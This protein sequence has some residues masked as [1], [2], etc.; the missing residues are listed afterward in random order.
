MNYHRKRRIL[1]LLYWG[2]TV[3]VLGIVW[4]AG[5][6]DTSLQPIVSKLVVGF[7]LLSILVFGIGTSLTK[8][9][10][11]DE[12]DK[13]GYR[14]RSRVKGTQGHRDALGDER[15][16]EDGDGGRSSLYK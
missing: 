4:Y 3:A 7:M 11:A 15:F 1:Y 8:K 16:V 2:G 6:V 13:G 12:G 10:K 14:Q 5:V 9:I